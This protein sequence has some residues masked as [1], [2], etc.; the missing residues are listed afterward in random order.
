MIDLQTCFND[1]PYLLLQ[2]DSLIR[3]KELPDNSIDSICTDCPYGLGKEPD[4]M[5]NAKRLDRN[6][7]S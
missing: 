6:R 7:A 5:P 1:R 4:A 2:G 3:L